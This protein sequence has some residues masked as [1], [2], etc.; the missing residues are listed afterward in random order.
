LGNSRSLASA[1]HG[2]GR[3]ISRFELSRQGFEGDDRSLGLQGV[4]CITLR[5]ERRIEEAPIAYKPIQPVIESQVKAG[6]VAVV[7]KMQPILTFKA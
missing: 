6:M 1:S 2:A 7:A 4:D 5:A 3:A